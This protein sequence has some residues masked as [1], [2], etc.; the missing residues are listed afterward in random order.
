MTDASDGPDFSRG[1]FLERPEVCLPWGLSEAEALELLRDARVRGVGA[2]RL[3]ARCHLLGGFETELELRF[4][5]RKAGRLFQVEFLRSP[6]RRRR[7]AF[8]AWQ[9]L[10]VG[11][12]GPG[13]DGPPHAIG[14]GLAQIVPSTWKLGSVAVT[15]DYFYQGAHYE[16]VLFSWA[17][18]REVPAAR[19]DEKSAE[20]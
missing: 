7:Q 10:L 18:Y 13:T 17:G 11:W 14:K 6:K 4:R 9:Q 8:E 16:K 2:G 5:P 15:H 1:F 19:Q 3:R 12:L 20:G